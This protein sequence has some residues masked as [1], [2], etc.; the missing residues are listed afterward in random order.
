MRSAIR[1]IIALA[2][3]ASAFTQVP[4]LGPCPDLP[5]MQYFDPQKYLGKWYEAERY[6]ALFEFGGKCVT[7][8]YGLTEQ[9]D[10]VIIN[11]QTSAITGI[12]STI[13]GLGNVLQRSDHAKLSIKFP[14]LRGFVNFTA[15]YWILDTDYDNYSLVWSCNNF[16][17]FSTKNAWILTRS[18]LPSLEII[19]HAYK[20]LD[21]IGINRA[22]FIRTDQKNC[23]SIY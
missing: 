12:E 8:D 22:Y 23:P 6:F 9:G 13:E 21:N 14:S 1:L 15:P 17:M 11:R 19:G 7:G 4:F 10:I 3:A 5:T 18:R 20:I 2:L 16:G